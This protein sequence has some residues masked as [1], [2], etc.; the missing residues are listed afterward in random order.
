[1]PTP[2]A[3]SMGT[4]MSVGCS[5]RAVAARTVGPPHGTMFN[6]PFIN[7]ATQVRTTGLMPRRR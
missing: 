1:M 2:S 7:P 4:K 5:P 6:V 3:G